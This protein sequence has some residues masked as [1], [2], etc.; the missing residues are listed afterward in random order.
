MEC[1]QLN[2]FIH[3]TPGGIEILVFLFCR[4]HL[5][6]GARTAS[7]RIPKDDLQHALSRPLHH[8]DG[9]VVPPGIADRT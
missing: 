8:S 4:I 5:A 3:W 9:S 1:Q 2:Y 7:C 6:Y